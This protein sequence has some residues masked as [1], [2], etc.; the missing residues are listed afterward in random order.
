M[1]AE[2]PTYHAYFWWTTYKSP[3]Y[4]K[5]YTTLELYWTKRENKDRDQNIMLCSMLCLLQHQPPQ[6]RY[7][8]DKYFGEKGKDAGDLPEAS[9]I[10]GTS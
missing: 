2:L 5:I 10:L 7:C 8:Y 4:T 1:K 3:A 9:T 6:E